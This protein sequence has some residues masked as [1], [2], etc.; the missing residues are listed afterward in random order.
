MLFSSMLFSSM[1]VFSASSFAEASDLF[2]PFICDNGA[3]SEKSLSLNDIL[4]DDNKS[5]IEISA[6]SSSFTG[7]LTS[8]IDSFSS[9]ETLSSPLREYFGFSSATLRLIG[10]P[11]FSSLTAAATRLTRLST[12]SS[13]EESLSASSLL[14]LIIFSSTS[15]F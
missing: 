15:I 13:D 4:S 12:S 14:S 7:P 1:L 10:L 5:S 11:F 2:S 8:S 9:F 3:S 6:G